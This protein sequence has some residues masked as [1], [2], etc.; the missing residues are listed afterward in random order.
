MKNV[1][2][3]TKGTTMTIVVDT[4]K[5]YG[6]SASGKS[7]IIASTE[8]NMPISVGDEN[9]IVGINIYRKAPKATK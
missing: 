9:I 4:T 1:T 6:L 3:T 7:Q 2:I 8:G 5:D